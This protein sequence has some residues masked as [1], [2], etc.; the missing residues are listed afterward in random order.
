MSQKGL[1][2]DLLWS[3]CS[4]DFNKIT[5]LPHSHIPTF[6]TLNHSPTSHT[7]MPHIYNTEAWSHIHHIQL[8]PH[9]HH[10]KPQ[11]HVHHTDLTDTY[12]LA[13]I[14]GVFYPCRMQFKITSC[15]RNK[16]QVKPFCAPS[17]SSALTKLDQEAS[18][19]PESSVAGEQ[20][21]QCSSNCPV[22]KSQDANALKLCPSISQAEERAACISEI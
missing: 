19:S 9:I 6:I 4:H 5:H 8:W 14:L 1:P 13:Q 18:F 11:S 21:I 22:I 2:G 15:I 3:A 7:S 20:K 16:A 12:M 10:T 17:F